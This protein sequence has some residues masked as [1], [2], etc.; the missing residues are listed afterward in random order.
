MAND[1]AI[2]REWEALNKSVEAELP[3]QEQAPE[4]TEEVA[5][6]TPEPAPQPAPKVRQLN[7]D[8]IRD[9]NFKHLRESKRELE[10][11][12]EE[13]ARRV[14]SLSNPKP[15]V[16]QNYDIGDEDVA[17]GSHV[18][19]VKEE[20]DAVRKELEAEKQ[21]R[22]K[23]LAETRLRAKYPDVY[24][25][26][27]EENFR[28][29]MEKE[30]E[31]AQTILSDPNPYT[32]HV[33]AYKAIKRYSIGVPETYLQDKARAQANMAKPKSA[34]TISPKQ[35]ESPLGMVENYYGPMSS[36]EKARLRKET[37]DA[38]NGRFS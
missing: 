32:Q 28:T 9:E 5:E 35:N 26:V 30:P 19:R 22:T 33:S 24:D 31:E 4:Q 1:D 6:T 34:A 17:M 27:N 36:E 15:A 16:P 20:L 18:K 13:L 2:R 14:E 12:Y 25:V 10:R 37:E 29:L 7:D 8:E 23:V 3:Q 21:E 11:K 38:I